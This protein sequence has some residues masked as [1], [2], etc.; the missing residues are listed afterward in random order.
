MCF[1]GS[2]QLRGVDVKELSSQVPTM[3]TVHTII[4]AMVQKV[5][6]IVQADVFNMFLHAKV[7]VDV[8]MR[9]PPWFSWASWYCM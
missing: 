1:N 7:D 5:A 3:E 9:H 2:D 6:Y 8:Y 4:T